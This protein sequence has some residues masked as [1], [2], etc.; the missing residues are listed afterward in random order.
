[1]NLALHLL[2]RAD[3]GASHAASLLSR[4][5]YLVSRVEDD[6]LAERLAGAPHIAG[7]VVDL[8]A[9]PAIQFGRKLTARY[10]EGKIVLVVITAAVPTAR[11]A[12]PSAL[13]LT[14]FEVEDDLI[15]TIDL[16]L[17]AHSPMSS[18]HSRGFSRMN[19]SIMATQRGS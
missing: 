13:V 7:V 14:P 19:A 3:A 17:A 5:G 6:A 16:A 15:S 8:P 2:L 1:M 11:K 4:S 10:G 12:L 18:F 9:L